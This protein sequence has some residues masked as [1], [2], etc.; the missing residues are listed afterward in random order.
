MESAETAKQAAKLEGIDLEQAAWMREKENLMLS[1]VR[2]LHELETARNP[3][4][5]LILRKG[6]ADL[7]IKIAQF[8]QDS[9]PRVRSS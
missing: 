3:R 8:G 1:R 4:Y 7:E 6:L 2:V 5:Q 9:S